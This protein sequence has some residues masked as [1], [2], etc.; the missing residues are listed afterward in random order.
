[1]KKV[2]LSTALTLAMAASVQAATLSFLPGYNNITIGETVSVDVE[3]SGLEIVDLAGF[4]LDVNFEASVLNFTGYILYGELGTVPGDAED[5]SLGDDGSGTINLAEMSWLGDLSGQSDSFT[6][7]TL[8][9][10][11]LE[12]G[13]SS[14]AFTYADLSDDWGDVITADTLGGRVDINAVPLPGAVWLFGSGLVG[15]VGLKRKR[16]VWLSRAF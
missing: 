3:I 11:G 8:T 15:F 5:L 6:L 16:T 10:E 9:F 12:V 2:L 13:S 1:M 7:A 14:L 4:D